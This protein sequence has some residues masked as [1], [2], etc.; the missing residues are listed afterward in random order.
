MGVSQERIGPLILKKKSKC[1]SSPEQNFFLHF[2]MRYPVRH[3]N[4]LKS[5]VDLMGNFWENPNLYT[6]GLYTV[7]LYSYSLHSHPKI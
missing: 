6:V 5:S 3:F 2:A 4:Y 7:G 1:T